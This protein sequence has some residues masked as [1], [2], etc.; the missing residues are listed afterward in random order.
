MG[1]T[2]HSFL[3]VLEADVDEERAAALAGAMRLLHGVAGVEPQVVGAAELMAQVR[4]RADLTAR[5]LAVTEEFM[6]GR[7]RTA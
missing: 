6:R 4:A 7:G 1:A 5:L 2:V 3:V